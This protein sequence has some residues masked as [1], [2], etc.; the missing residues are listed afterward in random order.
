MRYVSTTLFFV[1][2]FVFVSPVLFSAFDFVLCTN[3]FMDDQGR[4]VELWT[5]DKG[6]RVRVSWFASCYI[7]LELLIALVLLEHDP[8]V[9][10]H[11]Y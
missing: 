10:R 9:R 8:L 2:C 6:V 4:I 1:F 3:D 5:I 7:L 11:Q